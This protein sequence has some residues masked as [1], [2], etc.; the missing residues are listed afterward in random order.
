MC[1]CFT[2]PTIHYSLHRHEVEYKVNVLYD[3]TVNHD[4]DHDYMLPYTN[5]TRLIKLTL[6]CFNNMRG[7]TFMNNAFH[8]IL[9]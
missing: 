2:P 4:N 3:N 7:F 1:M 5:T 8:I 9:K 6:F